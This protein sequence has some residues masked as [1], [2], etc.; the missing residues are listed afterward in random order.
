MYPDIQPYLTSTLKV[1][2]LHTLY[3]EISGN[4]DGAPV[5]FLH[6]WCH[7]IVKRAIYMTSYYFIIL[8]DQRGSGKSLPSASLEENTTWDLVK[9]IEKLRTHLDIEK[10]HVFGGSWGSTLSLAYAQAS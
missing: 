4:K 2:D 7:S 10:W 6:G 3:Y 8:L 9:D 1:S 5:I